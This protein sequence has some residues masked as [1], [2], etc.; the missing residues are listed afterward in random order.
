[1]QEMLA[2]P[3]YYGLWSVIAHRQ[4]DFAISLLPTESAPC[5]L[6]L[7]LPVLTLGPPLHWALPRPPL[8][9]LSPPTC[10]L[11]SPT[12]RQPPIHQPPS[13]YEGLMNG[14]LNGQAPLSNVL[15]QGANITFLS[16]QPRGRILR[17]WQP[18]PPVGTYKLFSSRQLGGIGCPSSSSGSS[19]DYQLQCLLPTPQIRIYVVGEAAD[20]DGSLGWWMDNG[21]IL[22]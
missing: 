5:Q 6:H 7:P 14:R 12:D 9:P 18:T 8:P 21:F 15:P 22:V 20:A 19:T 1:M 4:S 3:E 13:Y 16:F 2:A 17:R 11:A 10:P